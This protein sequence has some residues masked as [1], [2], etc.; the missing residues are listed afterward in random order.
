MRTKDDAMFINHIT[1]YLATITMWTS[2]WGGYQVKW[3]FHTFL[4]KEFMNHQ[5]VHS[6]FITWHKID[7]KICQNI[8]RF[9]RTLLVGN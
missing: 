7:I 5:K 2:A 6:D 9:L 1:K 8:D 4:I 3:I